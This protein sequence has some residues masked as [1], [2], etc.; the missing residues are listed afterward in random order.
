MTFAKASEQIFRFN[1]RAHAGR[2]PMGGW[3]LL[4]KSSFNPRAHAGRDPISRNT[5]PTRAMFQ[6]TRPRGARQNPAMTF[7][8][9]MSFNPRAHAGR[10]ANPPADQP[11]TPRFNPRA[12]AGRDPG[13]DKYISISEVSIHA[14]TRGATQFAQGMRTLCNGFNPRAHAGRDF[15]AV[16]AGATGEC[17]NPRAHAGRDLSVCHRSAVGNVSIHAPTRGATKAL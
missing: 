5:S 1:P 9:A 17:F 6:S 13:A 14:P 11:P 3:W 7:Y 2:D 10:D 15:P 12:H 16:A 4:L 8:V